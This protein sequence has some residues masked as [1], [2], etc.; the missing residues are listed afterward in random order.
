MRGDEQ[1]QEE[2]FSY[3]SLSQRVP[4][5]HPLRRVRSMADEVMGSLET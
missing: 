2:M 5:D 3:G 1:H 4:L